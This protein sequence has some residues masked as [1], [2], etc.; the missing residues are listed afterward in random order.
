MSLTNA[1]GGNNAVWK[2][3]VDFVMPSDKPALGVELMRV[4]VHQQHCTLGL[5]PTDELNQLA[6]TGTI[7]NCLCI[8]VAALL[9]CSP[10]AVTLP[11]L[12]PPTSSS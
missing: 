5:V 11:P 1:S 8:S 4:N 6:R 3:T 9:S 7:S 10:L 2:L 12:F